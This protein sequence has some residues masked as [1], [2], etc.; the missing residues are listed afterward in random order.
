[1]KKIFIVILLIIILSTLVFSLCSCEKANE[2]IGKWET[3][4]PCTQIG[5]CILCASSIQINKNG[6]VSYVSAK[7]NET[8]NDY[9]WSYDKTKKAYKFTDTTYE[10][11]TYYCKINKGCLTSFYRIED[12]DAMKKVGYSLYFTRA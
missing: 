2:I 6:T 7:D 3:N 9:T 8:Y 5:E 4:D 12:N 1:M 11:F 10:K